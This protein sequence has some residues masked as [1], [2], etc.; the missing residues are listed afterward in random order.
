M[1][2]DLRIAF[3]G[4]RKVAVEVLDYLIDTGV[5]P[6]ALLLPPPARASHDQALLARCR[7]LPPA[8]VLRGAAFRQPAGIALLRSLELDFLVSVHFPYL[9]PPDVLGLPRRGCLNLHPAYL[10]F[11]RGWH[12]ATWALLEGTPVG[13]TLHYMD[14]GIDTGAIVHQKQLQAGPGDTAADLYPRLFEAEVEVF[15][16]GWPGAAAGTT[17][18]VQQTAETGTSHT[19]TDLFRREVQCIDLDEQVRAGELLR[20]LRALTTSRIDEAAYFEDR[21]RRFRVQVK[22]TEETSAAGG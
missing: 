16:E 15:R 10:P 11:N 22:I 14:T 6:V 3:A 21:G 4:D 5:H 18:V 2:T 13:A 8:H 12:T 7:S 19:K 17:T 1:A 9:V 20:R